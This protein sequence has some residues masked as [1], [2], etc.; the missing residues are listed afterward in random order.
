MYI[1]I[2]YELTQSFA[3]SMLSDV[4]RRVKLLQFYFYSS[5]MI[6]WLGFMAYQ[7]L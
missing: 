6:G 4:K 1:I 5:K 2:Y 7:P 3:Y